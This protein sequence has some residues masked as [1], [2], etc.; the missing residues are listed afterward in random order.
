MSF[1]SRLC[2]RGVADLAGAAANTLE[3]GG[4]LDAEMACV[5]GDGTEYLHAHNSMPEKSA[6][7]A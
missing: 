2:K 6:V 5:F 4:G 1:L 7:L 3:E